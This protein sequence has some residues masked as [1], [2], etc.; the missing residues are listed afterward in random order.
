[1]RWWTNW[2]VLPAVL[3]VLGCTTTP[4]C[5]A[6][7]ALCSIT[8]P[9][10]GV[11]RPT[12]VD[13]QNS[14]GHCGGCF[15]SCL[16]GKC[17][18]GACRPSA[19]SPNGC[20]EPPCVET[21]TNPLH[22]GACNHRCPKA[23]SCIGGR[24]QPTE[25]GLCR[26]EEKLVD[27]GAPVARDTRLPGPV[28]TAAAWQGQLLLHDETSGTF[29]QAARDG[30]DWSFQSRVAQ[31][32]GRLL[33]SRGP[34]RWALN[35]AT[36]QGW[37]VTA[38]T[39]EYGPQVHEAVDVGAGASAVAAG[40]DWLWVARGAT[41]AGLSE[42]LGYQLDVER[43]PELAVRR[44]VEVRA[45]DG[46]AAALAAIDWDQEYGSTGALLLAFQGSDRLARVER[47]GGLALIPLPVEC[48]SV[49][50]L[51]QEGVAWI[52]LACGEGVVVFNAETKRS[53]RWDVPAGYSATMI[54]VTSRETLLVA[55]SDK[56]T[57]W[58]LSHTYGPF[59]EASP[60][61]GACDGGLT[62]LLTLP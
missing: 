8:D 38:A 49:F 29:W 12:C 31:P 1:M 7:E 46:G 39:L 28:T 42:V 35:A 33:F 58:R 21:E 32:P 48:P 19:C 13:I 36:G 5:A 37:R 22:C 4:V 54:D 40:L 43:A 11:V 47:D 18:E 2:V 15:L 41:D 24:C 30:L 26:S 16:G 57:R 20:P 25:L 3:G 51:A 6:S 27:L 9:T 34:D 14:S 50:D 17:A 60:A 61:L 55:D 52:A 53:A 56:G 44:Q 10:T 45:L 23:M 62:A 59:V